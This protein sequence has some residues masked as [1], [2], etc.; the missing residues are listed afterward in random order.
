MAPIIPIP[1]QDT[2][3]TIQNA[4]KKSI[5]TNRILKERENMHIREDYQVMEVDLNNKLSLAPLNAN[6]N[7]FQ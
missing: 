6:F 5:D 7:S 3:K 4:L 2:L 1:A